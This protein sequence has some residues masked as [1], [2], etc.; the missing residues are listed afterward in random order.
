MFSVIFDMDGTLLDTQKVFIPAFDYAASLQGIKLMDN[1]LY[2]VCGSNDKGRHSYM[3]KNYPGID[4]HKFDKD[5][6]EYADKHRVVRFKKGALELLR[7]LKS[8]NIKMAVA[9]GSNTSDIIS[10]MSKLDALDF[11]DVIIGGE[12]VENC[13]PAPDI[14]LFAAQKLC[15]APETCFAFEDSS[16]GIR[17]AES[18]GMKCFG[19]WDVAPFDDEIK[20]VMYKE[21]NSL[22]EAI[23][24]LKKFM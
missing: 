23:D 22:D 14:Y 13:K 11:F 4:V 21:L 12:Q 10:N 6:F 9:S 2:N 20:S 19:I 18:A 1:C 3:S 16:N 17:S 7:F 15:V 8:N 5:M 24:V